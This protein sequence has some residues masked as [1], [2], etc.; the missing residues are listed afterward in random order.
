MMDTEYLLPTEENKDQIMRMFRC[1]PDAHPPLEID[2]GLEDD[3]FT[4]MKTP[5]MQF[6]TPKMRDGGGGFG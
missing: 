4:T 6:Q 2:T 3:E 5:K 1:F